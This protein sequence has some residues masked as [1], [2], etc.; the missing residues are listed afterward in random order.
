LHELVTFKIAKV[1][2]LSFIF[3]SGQD[4]LDVVSVAVLEDVLFDHEISVSECKRMNSELLDHF[5]QLNVV[6]LRVI[7]EHTIRSAALTEK[8]TH[9]LC[10]S[11]IITSFLCD[12]IK[13]LIIANPQSNVPGL[14]IAPTV[15]GL[16]LKLGLEGGGHEVS[17]LSAV[18]VSSPPIWLRYPIWL[19]SGVFCGQLDNCPSCLDPSAIYGRLISLCGLSLT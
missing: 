6:Q 14:I 17:D 1:L 7:P 5:I 18:E 12:V 19:P 11:F 3:R 4:G 9:K 2:R 15:V 16:I 13:T 8:I 10:E